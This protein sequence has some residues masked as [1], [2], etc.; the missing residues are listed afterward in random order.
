MAD[1][2][3]GKDCSPV[4]GARNGVVGYLAL[5]QAGNVQHGSG[6]CTV[7][8]L[9][10]IDFVVVRSQ[11][12]FKISVASRGKSRSVL[13]IREVPAGVVLIGTLENSTQCKF[14]CTPKVQQYT[15]SLI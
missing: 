15:N 2:R 1:S 5:H 12:V 14:V 8:G 6:E 10:S 11:Y 7:A 4:Q 9:R 13:S 3:R